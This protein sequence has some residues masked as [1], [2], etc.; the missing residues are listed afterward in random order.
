MV[1][2]LEVMKWL[3]GK[4][5]MPGIHIRKGDITDFKVDAIVNAANC[6]L[7][8]G[9]GLAGA[10]ARR[11]GPAI[12]EQCSSGGPIKIGQAAITTAANLPAKF[13]IHAAS[14]SLGGRT[15]AQ[16]LAESVRASLKLAEAHNITSIAFPAIGTGIAGFPIDQC[17][18]IMLAIVRQHL[19]A[20][21]QLKEV[22]FVLYDG[23]KYSIF[24]DCY[25]KM[26]T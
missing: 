8:L 26:V 18:Q 12:Q 2:H 23:S 24:T 3:L 22:Y 9:G 11:G 10:I 6:Q 17:A 4:R 16:S 20:K 1:A 5:L 25:N 14:M 15:T 13:V 21:S 7:I 19:K